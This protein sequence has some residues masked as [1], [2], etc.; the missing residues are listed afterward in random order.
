MQGSLRFAM[1]LVLTGVACTSGEGA[2]P[3]APSTGS[4][5]GSTSGPSTPTPAAS[6]PAA[7]PIRLDVVAALTGPGADAVRPYLEGMRLAEQEANAAGGLLGRPFELSFHDDEGGP[8]VGEDAMANLLA[9]GSLAILFVGPGT[10]VSALRSQFLQ[11]G[12][13]VV[14]LE[15]DLYTSH[16]LFPQVFQVTLP[17]EWQAG[18]IAR[19]VVTDR[20]AANVVFVGSGPEAETAGEA[21]GAAMAYWGGELAESF[22]DQDS[23]AM[24]GRSEALERAARADWTVVFGPGG[25]ALETVNAIEE[26]TDPAAPPGITGSAGLLARSASLAHPD[27]GTSACYTYTWAGWAL[28][29][30]RVGSFADRF[31]AAFGHPPEGFEQ[32]G[33]DAVRVLIEGLRATGGAGGSDL[34]AAI[35]GASERTF[36]SF[37]IAFGPDDHVFLPRSELGL[38]A[39]PGPT[40][41][42]DPWQDRE[43]AAPL[44][45]PVMR[46]FTYDGERDAV[47]DRDR[48]VFFPFWRTNQPGPEY[49]RSRYGIVSG[50]EDPLH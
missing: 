46:T 31:E 37:P 25:A 35:E 38:F 34:V 49:W 13:P 1:V 30:P 4:H 20:R 36:S 19:Y 22:T 47:L 24:L 45:R 18:A 44:W 6:G 2:P 12:T 3:P 14:L 50:P 15:G 48:R 23:D 11:S 26:V 41:P 5:L 42:L 39:V 9:S 7:T 8:D 29:I 21:L 40:E 43:E 10:S 27:P 16:G 33:F 28:P 17:W 32:E